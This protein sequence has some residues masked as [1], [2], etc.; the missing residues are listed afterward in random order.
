MPRFDNA[1]RPVGFCSYLWVR[2]DERP[3][4]LSLVADAI[5]MR[6]DQQE[7]RIASRAPLAASRP[8]FATF[9]GVQPR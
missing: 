1:R 6:H 2:G 9:I 4:A 3:N 7:G 5:S 8:S